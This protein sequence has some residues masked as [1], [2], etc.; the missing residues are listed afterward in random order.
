MTTQVLRDIILPALCP[1]PNLNSACKKYCRWEPKN[2]HI[3]R[4]F[5]GATG[6]IDDI[7]LILVTAEPGKP[8]DGEHYDGTP[9][10]MLKSHLE[11]FNDAIRNDLSRRGRRT[12]FHRG[13]REILNCCWPKYKDDIGAQMKCTWFT[14]SVLCSVG[15]PGGKVSVDVANSCTQ[16]YLKRQIDALPRAYVIA[17]GGKARDRLQRSAVRM[18]GQAQHPSARPKTK[19]ELSWESAGKAFQDWLSAH[20]RR[21]LA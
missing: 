9:A 7:R 16:T 1:C 18:N 2:G 12:P 20:E 4:G 6:S 10:E 5:G 15:I 17:L 11:L 13:L 19:P 14:N 21:S 3:P 8:A